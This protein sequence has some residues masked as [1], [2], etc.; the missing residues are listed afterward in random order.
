VIVDKLV[1]VDKMLLQAM[2]VVLCITQ[3]CSR[4]L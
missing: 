4:C 1:N 3:W 2:V